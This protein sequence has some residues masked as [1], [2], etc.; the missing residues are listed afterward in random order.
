MPDIRRLI[1][2]L[3]SPYKEEVKTVAGKLHEYCQEQNL[4]FSEL[5]ASIQP[6]TQGAVHTQTYAGPATDPELVSRMDLA[7]Q[8]LHWLAPSERSR[9]EVLY[10]TLCDQDVTAFTNDD[11]RFL[12]EI[13]LRTGV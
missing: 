2:Q 4:T 3:D 9:L 13:F 1:K 11:H 12:D 6:E 8:M 10:N 7:S 5:L